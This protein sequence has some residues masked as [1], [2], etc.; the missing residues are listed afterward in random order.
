MMVQDQL[1]FQ[2]ELR[3]EKV[4]EENMFLMNMALLN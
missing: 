1:N 4:M 2:K 3:L